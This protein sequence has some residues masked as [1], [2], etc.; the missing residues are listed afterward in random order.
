MTSF[1][2]FLSFALAASLFLPLVRVAAGPTHFDRLIGLAVMGTNT[3][4]LLM[5]VGALIGRLDLFVDIALSYAL[6]SFIGTLALAR[7]FER[8]GRSGK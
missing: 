7:H 2:H 6:V 4:M 5:T 1:L 3:V 8:R